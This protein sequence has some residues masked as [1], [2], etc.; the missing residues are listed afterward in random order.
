MAPF[1]VRAA[2]SWSGVN[3]SW[4]LC[5]ICARQVGQRSATFTTEFELL[6]IVG[7]ALGASI[8]GGLPQSPQNLVASG[9]SAWLERAPLMA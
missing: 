2:C 1:A 7:A 3:G 4:L 9:F 8:S 6:R 5:S